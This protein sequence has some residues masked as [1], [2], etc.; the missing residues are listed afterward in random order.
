MS[1]KNKKNYATNCGNFASDS[2][3][4]ISVAERD[5]LQFC[6]FQSFQ[7]STLFP[8]RNKNKNEV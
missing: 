4:E 3:S 5:L 2:H 6:R 8:P 1:D 7:A